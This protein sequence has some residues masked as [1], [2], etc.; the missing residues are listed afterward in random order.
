M[1]GRAYAETGWNKW[2]VFP[3]EVICIA[4]LALLFLV[5]LFL[6]DA[7]FQRLS[8]ASLNGSFSGRG[9]FAFLRKATPQMERKSIAGFAFVMI[10]LWLPYFIA[11]FP[12]VNGWDTYNQI[13]QCYPNHGPIRIIPTNPVHQLYDAQ[14][15]DA[16]PLF[17]TLLFGAFA[18]SSEALTGGWNAG[19]ALYSALQSIVTATTFTFCCAYMRHREVPLVLCLA[20]YLFYCLC[21]LFGMNAI[22]IIKDTLFSWI[23]V[24][25][26][27]ATL[28][29][30]RTRGSWLSERRWF[31]AFV[32]LSLLLA[33]TKKTGIYV[34]CVET[35]VLLVCYRKQWIKLLLAGA[36]P[37]L[38][39]WVLFPFLVFPALSV[40]PGGEQEALGILFQQTARY[41]V[42]YGNEVTEEERIAIDAV[43]PYERLPELYDPLKSDAVKYSYR[44]ETV[45][46][47][48]KQ[49]YYHAWLSMFLR[50]PSSSIEATFATIAGFFSPT[51]RLTIYTTQG[52]EVD[53][54]SKAHFYDVTESLR[55]AIKAWNVRLSNVPVLGLF[56][57]DF[58]YGT[59]V[60]LTCFALL[61]ARRRLRAIVPI[62]MLV[63]LFI[64][65]YL[66]APV[67]WTRYLYPLIYIAPLLVGLCSLA[68]FTSA[69]A[70]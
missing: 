16:N 35:V 29:I 30:V 3:T 69:E 28:E 58:V 7:L 37:S 11:F 50:H 64:G 60:P 55:A 14:F 39:I 66:I 18:L 51:K 48:D 15:V 45:R 2:N 70:M 46:S 20:S 33:L 68:Y 52:Q 22:T 62:V 57:H 40:L 43:L 5:G 24:W 31:I 41:V 17:D 6:V 4:S 26:F 42:E 34:V 27:L 38:T 36:I 32:V 65:S 12:G 21:P 25:Y 8:S 56:M 47:E 9:V 67:A 61:W 49:R 13:S 54:N 10:L 23:S 63:V 1:F 44:L 53:Q 19:L 59:L